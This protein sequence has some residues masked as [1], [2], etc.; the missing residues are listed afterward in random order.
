MGP[1]ENRKKKVTILILID[2][3]LQSGNWRAGKQH[4]GVT[5][6]ILIDGFLQSVINFLAD[7]IAEVTILIL[8]DGFLQFG[9]KHYI[10]V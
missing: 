7:E 2:G 8:I 3:F 10:T 5:I 1:I 6:L 9:K 4:D